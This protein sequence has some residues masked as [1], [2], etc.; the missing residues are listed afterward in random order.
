VTA[1]DQMARLAMT[2][3]EVKPPV[4]RRVEVPL[5]I[6]LDRLHCVFQ[7]VMDPDWDFPRSSP[8]LGEQDDPG[9]PARANPQQDLQVSLRPWRRLAV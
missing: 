6:R 9:Q 4:R 8:A 1:Q 3:D 5:S 7:I 2:L